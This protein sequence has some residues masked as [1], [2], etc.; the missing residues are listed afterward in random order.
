[1]L[2]RDVAAMVADPDRWAQAVIDELAGMPEADAGARRV[3]AAVGAARTPA[4]VDQLL[5]AAHRGAMG[6]AAADAVERAG[7][8]LLRWHAEREAA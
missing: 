3:L 8:E 4:A 2:P 7:A 1:M 5:Q 6:A